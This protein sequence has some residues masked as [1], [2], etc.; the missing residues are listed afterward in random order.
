MR[1]RIELQPRTTEGSRGEERAH[2]R[3]INIKNAKHDA[4]VGPLSRRN[5]LVNLKKREKKRQ[6]VSSL[7]QGAS[8]AAPDRCWTT[9]PL[10][11]EG[12]E[13]LVNGLGQ[14]QARMC[15]GLLRLQA[16]R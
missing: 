1:G 12:E 7:T 15:G 4:V 3:T 5:R 11:Q 8:A 13:P 10:D 6:G 2:G 16:E 9:H 14:R